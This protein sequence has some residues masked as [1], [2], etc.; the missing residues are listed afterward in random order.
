LDVL[1]IGGTRNLGHLLSLELLETGHQVTVF[2]RGQTPDEGFFEVFP[3][4]V[5]FE[6]E[7]RVEWLPRGP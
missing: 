4:S 6:N 2:N 7:G 5:A 1:I 3:E